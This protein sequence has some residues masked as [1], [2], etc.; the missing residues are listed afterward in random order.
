M[1]EHNIKTFFGVLRTETVLVT[2][3]YKPEAAKVDSHVA[4][5]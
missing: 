5:L 2:F 4:R 1:S 3:E